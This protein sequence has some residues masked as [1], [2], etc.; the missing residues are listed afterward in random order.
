MRL[1]LLRRSVLQNFYQYLSTV[2]SDSASTRQY[3]WLDN[4]L[5]HS[6]ARHR[7]QGKGERRRAADSRPRRAGAESESCLTLQRWAGDCA[8]PTARG[9]G[10]L[11]T[12][13]EVWT[14]V[15]S[16]GVA[17][18]NQAFQRGTSV[19]RIREHPTVHNHGQRGGWQRG[20]RG[21]VI[22]VI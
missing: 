2:A 4:I 18:F 19:I 13:S 9:R 8:P 6:S 5:Q 14:P 21:R 22:K 11:A 16:H 17:V 10:R 15:T 20:G 7:A 1:S 12:C 3:K